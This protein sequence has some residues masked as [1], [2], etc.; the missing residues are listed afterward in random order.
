MMLNIRSRIIWFSV[1]PPDMRVSAGFFIQ[2]STD[3]FWR[4]GIGHEKCVR[5]GANRSDTA[6]YREDLQRSGAHFL[7]AET[8]A[9]NQ[10]VLP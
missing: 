10:S 7:V 8:A 9:M 4:A 2:G 3:W 6:W 1:C 5:Q